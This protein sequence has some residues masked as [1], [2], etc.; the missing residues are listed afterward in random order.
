MSITASVAESFRI[1][2]IDH[3]NRVNAAELV[4]YSAGRELLDGE[5]SFRRTTN[6][7]QATAL[8]DELDRSVDFAGFEPRH[9]TEVSP[10][11]YVVSLRERGKPDQVHF[12]KRLRAGYKLNRTKLIA[13]VFRDGT[14]DE[15]NEEPMLLSDD[16]D[17]VITREIMI[18]TNQRH[19]DEA[20]GVTEEAMEA[21]KT[22]LHDVT[23][24]LRFAN[25]SDFED[26]VVGD[27]NMVSKLRSIVELRQDPKFR[28][29]MTMPRMVD[30]VRKN[31]DLGIDLTGPTGQEAFVYHTDL[32]RRWKL[33][34]LLDDEFLRSVITDLDYEANS[35]SRLST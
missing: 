25:Y 2:V 18:A 23:T 14:Y 8:L 7:P 28:D 4:P 33:L 5:S 35:K 9:M 32:Q 26:A 24:D 22:M 1:R 27:M 6:M 10:R 30:F 3:V 29:A 16:F 34:R 12:L 21:A 19:V 15:M 11:F 17:A 20:L 31:P 13:L